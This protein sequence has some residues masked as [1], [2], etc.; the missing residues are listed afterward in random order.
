MRAWATPTTADHAAARNQDVAH[1]PIGAR[2]PVE[3]DARMEMMNDVVLH[4]HRGDVAEREAEGA[5]VA[6]TPSVAARM[7]RRPAE[8][9]LDV[10]LS[11]MARQP[12]QQR[13]L[14]RV[15][16]H[17]SANNAP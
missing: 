12:P 3:R 2:R 11:D 13:R 4:P 7:M 16:D 6:I 5:R 14:D 1:F 8:E 15:P 10:G 9:E 17:A